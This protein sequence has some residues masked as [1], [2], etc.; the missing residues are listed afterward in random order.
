MLAMDENV[1]TTL[2]FVSLKKSGERDFVFHRGA[3]AFLT[4]DDID[5]DKIRNAKIVH[6]GSATT[7]HGKNL[8]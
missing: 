7:M 8:M 4:L 6:F 1:P 3:D 5:Q 2:A